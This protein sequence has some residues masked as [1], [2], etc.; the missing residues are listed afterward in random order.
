MQIA[1]IAGEKITALI[2]A[3][4]SHESYL[5]QVDARFRAIE[6][7]AGRGPFNRRNLENII[8]VINY[9]S[10]ENR[11]PVMLEPVFIGTMQKVQRQA[12]ELYP[13]QMGMA[14]LRDF[15]ESMNDPNFVS[16]MLKRYEAGDKLLQAVNFPQELIN[17]KTEFNK[18]HEAFQQFQAQRE[19]FA[20]MVELMKANKG[21]P[22]LEG[23]TA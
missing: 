16:F 2:P 15:G 11:N 18:L 9:Y 21:Q 12:Q 1:Q 5:Y 8:D 3:I 19:Q 6:M 17:E 14:A 23:Q 7:A 4:E 10:S 22:M 13:L 20:Q